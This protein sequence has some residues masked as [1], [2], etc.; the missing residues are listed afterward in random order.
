MENSLGCVGIH[1]FKR[2][3]IVDF[4]GNEWL[5][6]GFGCFTLLLVCRRLDLHIVVT[7][8]KISAE[9]RDLA[10]LFPPKLLE[11]H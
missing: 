2:L 11:E 9:K 8:N 3:R 7:R 4:D 1:S 6:S 10:S 5:D